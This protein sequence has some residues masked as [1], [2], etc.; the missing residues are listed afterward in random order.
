MIKLKFTQYLLFIIS[1]IKYKNIFRNY[2]KMCNL[3]TSSQYKNVI[4]MLLQFS[5]PIYN[6]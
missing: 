1:N 4:K 5:E 3:Q 2:I 6:L